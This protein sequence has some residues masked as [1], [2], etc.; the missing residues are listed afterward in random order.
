[1]I[2]KLRGRETDE[3]E[4]LAMI[5]EESGACEIEATRSQRLERYKRLAADCEARRARAGFRVV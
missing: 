3:S 4:L 2:I 1:M 5:L